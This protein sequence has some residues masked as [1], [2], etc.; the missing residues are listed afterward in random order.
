MA[1]LEE[2]RDLLGRE[3]VDVL[4]QAA[5]EEL[6]ALESPPVRKRQVTVLWGDVKGFTGLSERLDAEDLARTMNDLWERLD[7][8]VDEHGG[9]VDKHVGDALVAVWGAHRSLEDDPV[10]AARAALAMQAALDPERPSGPSLQMRI[11]LH[12]GPALLGSVD[13]SSRQAVSGEA[14]V[15]AEQIQRAVPPGR[16]G[17]SGETLQFLMRRFETEPGESDDGPQLLT[18]ERPHPEG[19]PHAL[20]GRERESACLRQSFDRARADSRVKWVDVVGEAG[21]GKTHLLRG[22]A[23]ELEQAETPPV[24]L[25]GH[26]VEGGGP[27][28][29]VRGMFSSLFQIRASDPPGVARRKLLEGLSSIVGTP[30]GRKGLGAFVSLLGL[31]KDENQPSIGTDWNRQ[32][33]FRHSGDL[34]RQVAQGRGLVLIVDDIQQ[35]DADTAALLQYWVEALEWEPVLLLTTRRHRSD[36]LSETIDLELDLSPLSEE[37]LRQLVQ[38]L[39]PPGA[40]PPVHELV[41]RFS[42]GTPL[43]AVELLQ[44]LV[45]DGSL[46]CIEN[47]WRFRDDY[48]PRVPATLRGLLDARLDRL[49]EPAQR[50]LERAAV[51]GRTFWDQLLDDGSGDD[52]PVATLKGL[53]RSG[54]LLAHPEPEFFGTLEFEF[55]HGLLREVAYERVLRPDRRR[56][57]RH[58]AEWLI[59]HTADRSAEWAAAI[60]VHLDRADHVKAIDWYRK[61]G[62]WARAFVSISTAVEHYERAA[63]LAEAADHPALAST[64]SYLGLLLGDASRHAEALAAYRRMLDIA[65]VPAERIEALTGIAHAFGEMGNLDQALAAASEALGLSP[66][67]HARRLGVLQELGWLHYRLG[68]P[69][70]A[71]RFGEEML[72]LEEGWVRA[73]DRMAEAHNLMGAACELGGRFDEARHHKERALRYYRQ[74]QNVRGQNMIAHNLA[75][76][77][78]LRGDHAE[79]LER[80]EAAIEDSRRAGFRNVELLARCGRAGSLIGLGAYADAQGALDRLLEDCPPHWYALPTAQ[81]FLAEALLGMGRLEPAEEA[82]RRSLA[83]AEKIQGVEDIGQAWRV[84]G[85]L[86]SRRGGAITDHS[87]GRWSARDCFEKGLAQ[88]DSATTLRSRAELLQSWGRHETEQ[89]DPE[90]GRA[91]LREAGQ[92]FERMG[93]PRLA[94]RP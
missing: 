31:N 42:E 24:I 75:E 11:G 13:D 71:L 69:E 53:V 41:Q 63:E 44:A 62:I 51:V 15:V 80:F 92:L 46:Q 89:G 58:T 35:A 37:H 22:F 87:G 38:I 52:G 61:A 19:G 17:V 32:S 14:T 4:L 60:A 27:Y 49:P 83:L 26:G 76:N 73:G 72:T 45:Q 9:S 55:S 94:E 91:L 21:L 12:T 39:L 81:R 88:L 30:P 84:V 54:L 33:V 3:S 78:R 82:A 90:R 93:L 64:L 16:I 68:R 43:Y 40:S 5:R 25:F 47:E 20:L 10:R 67:D 29:V 1:A 2:R 70:D 48:E 8:I 34:L 74:T 28:S 7:R 59:E 56:W 18:R 23:R 50:A 85:E 57:H 6:R 66:E 36:A 79:A 77:Y 65:S 86:A